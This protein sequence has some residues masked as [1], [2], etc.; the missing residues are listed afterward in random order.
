[1]NTG[2]IAKAW[3]LA[4]AIALVFAAACVKSEKPVPGS[5]LAQMA[6]AHCHEV[7]H[8]TIPGRR[9]GDGSPPPFVELAND[10]KVTPEMLY[11]FLRFPHGAM[12]YLFVTQQEANSL[13]AYIQSLKSANE[14]GSKTGKASV[15]GPL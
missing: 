10:P 5:A 4:A 3:P 13:I 9:M 1:M 2:T 12:D 7:T 6:C 11:E 8:R 15:G 14:S